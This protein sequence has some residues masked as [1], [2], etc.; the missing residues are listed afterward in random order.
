M[1][2]RHHRC[3]C[4]QEIFERLGSRLSSEIEEVVPPL[5]RKAAEVSTAGRENFLTQYADAALT[6]MVLSCSEVQCTKALLAM[7]ATSAS[8]RYVSFVV[9]HWQLLG[10]IL[11]S[12][13]HSS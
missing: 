11:Q 2:L 5:M 7:C 8:P 12:G 9:P 10:N 4:V 6:Q 3:R 1:W 13:P